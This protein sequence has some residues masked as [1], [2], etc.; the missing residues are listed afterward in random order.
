MT[1]PKLFVITLALTTALIAQDRGARAVPQWGIIDTPGNYVLL[2][3]ATQRSN[4]VGILITASNVSIDLNGNAV[5]G[6]GGSR[7]TGIHIR[8]ANGVR[9]SNGHIV[10]HAFGVI[11]ESSNNVMLTKLQIS[12]E[13]LA[14]PAPPPETAIMI[15]QSK[16]VVVKDNSIYNTGLGIFVRGGRSWGN[17]IENNTITG[18][19]N[20]ALGICYNP[21]PNDPQG[22]RGDLVAHNLVTGFNIGLQFSDNSMANVTKENTIAYRVSAVDFKNASNLDMNNTKIQL[23]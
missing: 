5:T 1:K 10:N 2:N 15:L 23:P 21:A 6:P 16:N 22:P 11:V 8:G 13:G 9:V 7:G 14:V 18:G 19:T 12:G 3:D 20:A 4:G 17:R